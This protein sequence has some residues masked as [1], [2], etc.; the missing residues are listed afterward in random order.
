MLS[1]LR[2]SDRNK[3]AREKAM[4]ESAVKKARLEITT[5]KTHLKTAMAQDQTRAARNPPPY[6]SRASPVP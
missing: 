1:G 6:T 4:K 3:A 2:R 5:P